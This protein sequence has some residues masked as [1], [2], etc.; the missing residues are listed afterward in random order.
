VRYVKERRHGDA[1]R[2]LLS[3]GG[4]DLEAVLSSAGRLAEGDGSLLRY[5]LR[6]QPSADLVS[7]LANQEGAD[8]EGGNE[9]QT[10][11]HAA[12]VSGCSRSVL[13][14]LAVDHDGGHHAGVADE[15]GRYPLHW[16]CVNPSNA[17]ER[18]VRGAV[19]LLLELHPGARGAR[20]AG[21]HAPVDLARA[22]GAGRSV[23]RL[24]AG[25]GP[26]EDDGSRASSSSLS[27]AFLKRPVA[28]PPS[29]SS[30]RLPPR[31]TLTPRTFC[32]DGASDAGTVDDEPHPGCNQH[33][34]PG[35][36]YRHL[37]YQVHALHDSAND[38]DDISS[39]GCGEE[40]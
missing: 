29:K 40:T 27:L 23:L 32:D 37:L 19:E 4:A 31:R 34:H 9:S 6:Q 1:L 3:L 36:D 5:A 22:R 17:G 2:L 12:V 14:V 30:L 7:F 38:D 11:L 26:G 39:L 21:G 25:D 10:L 24:L 28:L 18:A 13:E 20:D 35:P 15:T 8:G 16:A 33:H